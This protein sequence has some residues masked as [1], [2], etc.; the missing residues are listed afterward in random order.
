MIRRALLLE[1]SRGGQVF[2]L[3][4]RVETIEAQTEILKNL[5]PTVR[6][7]YAHGQMPE[8]ELQ[9]VIAR[10]IRRDLDVLVCT[11]IIESGIDMPSVNTIIIDR[12]DTFGLADLHQ[13]RG[14]VGRGS[15]KAYCYLFIPHRHV[16]G[17]ALRRL[18]AVEELSHLGAGFKIALK[19]LEI[20]GAGNILGVEQH[21][22]IAAVGYDLYC[23]LLKTTVMKMQDKEGEAEAEPRDV[24]L[25]I[26]VRAYIPPRFIPDEGLR[27][28]ILRRLSECREEQ[29]FRNMEEE[30]EDRFGRLLPEVVRLIDVF[31]IR[32]RMLDCGIRRLTRA[33]GSREVFVDLFDTERYGKRKPFNRAKLNTM[34]PT[35]AVLILPKGM[36]DPVDALGY[37]KSQLIDRGAR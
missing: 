16:S 10:F 3:H 12:A 24:D 11:T 26:Q 25:D 1:V 15:I 14:R 21:G 17:I 34:T 20:R 2:F 32:R 33:R 18:K 8:R 37:L 29:C 28:E 36:T 13:L 4:N 27:V 7:A 22:H 23:R 30:L 9:R 19:D 35:R 31:R 5:V 6:I